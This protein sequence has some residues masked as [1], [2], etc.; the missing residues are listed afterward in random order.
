VVKISAIVPVFNPGGNIDEC[1]ESLVGQSMP[2]G[3]YEVIFVD[4]GST[5]GTPARLDSLAASHPNVR[6]EHIPPSGWPGKPR[7]VGLSLARGEFVYFVDNDDWIGPEALERLHARAV[8]DGADVVIGKV[9]GRGK[10]VPRRLFEQNRSGVGLEWQPLLSLLTPHKLFRRSLLD[11]HGVRFPEGRRRLED[12]VFTMHAFFHARSVSIL[13]DYACYYWV[14]RA[15]DRDNASF[16]A[17]EPAQYYEN[18]REV[19]DLVVEHTEPGPLRERLLAHW[20][21]GKMLGRVGGTWFV[22]RPDAVRRAFF[23][24]VAALA[25]ERFGPWV[26]RWVP[27]NMR[28]R[29]ELLRRH[30]FDG[31]AAL[32][33]WEADLHADVTIGSDARVRPDGSFALP[34]TARLLDRSD[35][36]LTFARRG[37]RVCWAPPP[38]VVRAGAA[39]PESVLDVTDALGNATASLTIR[40]LDDGAEFV[41][42]ATVALEQAD[43]G[44]VALRGEA[45]VERGRA[46][47]G[48][49]LHAGRWALLG[50]V[51]VCGFSAI[52]RARE[53]RT[54]AEYG[55]TI[56]ARG[57]VVEHGSEGVSSAL[58]GKLARRLPGLAAAFRRAQRR[59]RAAAAAH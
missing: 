57:A 52:G 17:F 11:E 9:V 31:L 6:V 22:N 19:L 51:T 21:R 53:E 25:D 35:E 4:D 1:I 54:A 36:P 13:A 2:S 45:I 5:D 10:F 42:P 33:G 40:S 15:D 46:A 20:Y 18:L 12:H 8:A 14:L 43:G 49:G 26:D 34:F 55:I 32:A 23:A 58:K 29:S 24:E 44:A 39:L 59:R 27:A 56:D 41:L 37:A 28:V 7:N 30:D 38:D 50:T 3:D 16:Q 47:A 48:T